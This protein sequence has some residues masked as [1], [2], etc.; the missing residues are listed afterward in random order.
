M[1][2]E[3]PKRIRRTRAQIEADNLAKLNPPKKSVDPVAAAPVAA[4]ADVVMAEPEKYVKSASERAETV[5]KLERI[6]SG[7]QSVDHDLYKLDLAVFKRNISYNKSRPQLEDIEHVHHFHSVDSR[8]RPQEYSN[9]VGGH[10]H[11]I[12]YDEQGIAQCGPAVQRVKQ[13]VNGRPVTTYKEI[14][15]DKHTHAVSYRWSQKITPSTP[16][17]EWAKVQSQVMQKQSAALSARIPDTIEN[18]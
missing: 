12:T 7:Q 15:Y 6:Y 13:I 16:N 14:P 9:D 8:G 17:V 11:R 4:A 2:Q 1:D 18:E 5:K 10:T 3:L